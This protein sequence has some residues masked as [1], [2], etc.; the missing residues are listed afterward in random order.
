MGCGQSANPASDY[1]L[2]DQCL[3]CWGA[4]AIYFALSQ[5]KMALE[6]SQHSNQYVPR[7]LLLGIVQI[8]CQRS[9]RMKLD[10][11]M[12][13]YIT[14]RLDS[15]NGPL[16]LLCILPLLIWWDPNMYSILWTYL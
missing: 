3:N 9:I 6:L 7:A 5:L 14:L 2:D 8:T 12:M 15:T 16:M 1:R 13:E 4:F 11:C 10:N